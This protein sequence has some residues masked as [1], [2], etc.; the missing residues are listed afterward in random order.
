MLRLISLQKNNARYLEAF[1]RSLLRRGEYAEVP[2]WLSRL[3]DGAPNSLATVTLRVQFLCRTGRAADTLPVLRDYTDA[4]D[5][6][7]ED[8]AERALAAADLFDF[9]SAAGAGKEATTRR[10]PLHQVQGVV[11]AAE[12]GSPARWFLRSD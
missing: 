6:T 2:V 8:P 3:T 12:R 11:Q 5:G 10:T 9:A 4:K 1:V 7:P